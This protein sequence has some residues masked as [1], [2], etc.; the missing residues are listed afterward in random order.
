MSI[1][2]SLVLSTLLGRAQTVAH[3]VVALEVYDTVRRERTQKIV[4][5]SRET[6]II[7]TGKG[8]KTGLKLENLKEELPHRWDFIIS[9]DNK[10]HCEDAIKLME[11]SLNSI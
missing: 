6:G 7:M 9:F 8:S 3:A 1:E 4:V 2:D 5:S 11:S 10:K